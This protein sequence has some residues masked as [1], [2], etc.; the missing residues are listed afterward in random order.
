M[1]RKK[2]LDLDAVLDA[3][4]AVADAEGFDAVTLMA[5]A[6][7]LG[8]RSPSLYAHVAGLHGLR[9]AMALRAAAIL[10]QRLEEAVAP[11]TGGRA[12]QALA[13]AYRSLARERPGLYA[14]LQP[15]LPAAEDAELARALAAPVRVVMDVLRSMDV[16]ETNLVHAAR[17]LRSALHGFILLERF[18]GFGLPD[19]IEDSFGYLTSLLV[20][21]IAGVG[22]PPSPST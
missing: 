4:E 9:R 7:R 19:S 14:A 22:G 18:G 15:G 16:A 21:G 10:A 11:Y 17:S 2:G 6:Q 13:E 20:A 8:V 5:V 3:A 12:V 1:A